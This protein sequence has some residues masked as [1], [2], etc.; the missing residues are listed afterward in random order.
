MHEEQST[1][2]VV[3]D[4]CRAGEQ[5]AFGVLVERYQEVAFRTAF[6]L[7]RDADQAADVAQDAFVRAY[8]NLHRFEP[9]STF[10]PW[11]LRIVRNLALNE[12]RGKKRRGNLLARVGSRAETAERAPEGTVVEQEERRGLAE[13]INSLPENDRT[14]LYLRHYL[15]LPEAEIAT[16]IGKRPGTVKSRLSRASG[17]L[18]EVIER[19]YPSLVPQAV[20]KGGER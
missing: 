19:D 1:D 17:R 5:Q 2:Q 3:I 10:R 18:R 14:V 7:L 13:A 20:A 8:R 11:L 12:L 15:E 9:G 6:L 4:A 16:I